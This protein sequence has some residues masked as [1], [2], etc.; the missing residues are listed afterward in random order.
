MGE[1]QELST[2]RYCFSPKCRI[3]CAYYFVD[4]E[5]DDKSLHLKND[6]E[7]SSVYTGCCYAIKILPDTYSYILQLHCAV[8]M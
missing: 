3:K 4:F 8:G 7:R 5:M 2:K 1:V 6:S